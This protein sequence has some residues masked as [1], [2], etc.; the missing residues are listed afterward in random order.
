MTSDVLSGSGLSSSAAYEVLIGNILS[1]L[2]N[3][4]QLNPIVIAQIGQE[5][6]RDF[7]GK[8]CGLMD[9]MACSFGGMIFIDFEN[10]KYPLV[11][12]VD[13]DFNKFGY[14]LCIIDTKGSH[15]DLRNSDGD[16]P[17]C[18]LNNLLKYSG[19]SYPTISAI[20]VTL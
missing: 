16:I 20:S 7:F 9:Q 15:A 18:F 4:S 13:V 11:K 5:A 2:Y 12:K 10:D 17:L 1:G 8:P 14:S 3:D 19:L 6:E